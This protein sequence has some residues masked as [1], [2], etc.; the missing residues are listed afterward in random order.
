MET[1][2]VGDSTFLLI[3]W[4]VASILRS[5]INGNLPIHDLH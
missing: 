5:R 1:N 4:S 2:H 3:T